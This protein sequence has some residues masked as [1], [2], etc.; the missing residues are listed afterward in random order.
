MTTTRTLEAARLIWD[1]LGSHGTPS[2]PEAIVVCCSY[3]LRVCDFA[4]RQFLDS[5]ASTL[6]FSGNT[7]NWTR[8]LWDGPEALV[9]RERALSRGV[10]PAAIV[11]ETDSTNIGENILF[12]RRLLPDTSNV[13]FITKQNTLL[14]VKLTVPV[15]WPS[16]T[17]SYACPAFEFPGEVS[18]MVGVFGLINEMVGDLQRILDYPALGYQLPFQLPPEI[19]DAMHYLE[20]QGFLLHSNRA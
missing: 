18:N 15:Q 6:L 17:A 16:V 4:C 11:T 20:S 10:S 12:S 19:L 9:F 1:F 7:G 2:D 14:R 3:D 5:S 8:H 13:C